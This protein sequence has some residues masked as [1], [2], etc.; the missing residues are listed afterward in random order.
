MPV[1]KIFIFLDLDEKFS[2]SFGHKLL[3]GVE[4]KLDFNTLSLSLAVTL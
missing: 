2:F 4:I 3:K 1:V